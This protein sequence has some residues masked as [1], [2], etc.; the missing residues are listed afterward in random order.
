MT[1]FRSFLAGTIFSAFM[2]CLPGLLSAQQMAQLAPEH[3]RRVDPPSP[4]LSAQ[5]FELRVD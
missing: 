2:I 5:Q 3:L 4:A 1:F